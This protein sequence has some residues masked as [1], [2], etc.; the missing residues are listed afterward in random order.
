MNDLAWLWLCESKLAR[1]L[2]NAARL[3]ELGLA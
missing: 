1:H 2:V 3:R